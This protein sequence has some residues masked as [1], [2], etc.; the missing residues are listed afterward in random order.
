MAHGVSHTKAQPAEREE[1]EKNQQQRSGAQREFSVVPRRG[2][3]YF[4]VVEN[5]P[6][7]RSPNSISF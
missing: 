7:A 1:P 3:L 4:F 6:H 5:S 2:L